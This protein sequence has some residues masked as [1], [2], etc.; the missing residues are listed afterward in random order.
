[1]TGRLE[2]LGY[3]FKCREVSFDND[4]VVAKV[5]MLTAEEASNTMLYLCLTYKT[6]HAHPLSKKIPISKSWPAS[7]LRIGTPF[8][9]EM[10]PALYTLQ[11]E[12]LSRQVYFHFVLTG[13]CAEPYDACKS[14]MYHQVL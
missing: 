7:G 8:S 9:S 1:M 2:S 5:R 12:P 11:L 14:T 6:L 13:M 10:D 3:L 4:Q